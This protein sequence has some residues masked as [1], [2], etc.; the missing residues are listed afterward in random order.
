M[1]ES[2]AA[3]SS[4]TEGVILLLFKTSAQRCVQL[5]CLY[6]MKNVLGWDRAQTKADKNTNELEQLPA[7]EKLKEMWLNLQNQEADE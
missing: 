3:T 7:E 1:G 6:F 2:D 4:Q 5:W